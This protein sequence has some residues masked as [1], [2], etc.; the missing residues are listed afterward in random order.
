MNLG[1]VEFYLGRGLVNRNL[2]N[3]DSVVN[4]L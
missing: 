2:D 4:D 3:Y 1:F